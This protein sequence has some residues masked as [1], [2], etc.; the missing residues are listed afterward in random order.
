MRIVCGTTTTAGSRV[1]YDWLRHRK[2]F[3]NWDGGRG[4]QGS[5]AAAG[6][7][8]TRWPPR[9]CLEP[10]IQARG[11]LAGEFCDAAYEYLTESVKL[12]L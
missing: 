6:E 3:L 11:A 4:A 7:L 10:P 8:A 9:R 12:E 5:S 1:P 2:P